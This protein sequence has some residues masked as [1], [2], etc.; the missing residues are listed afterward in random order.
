MGDRST[1]DLAWDDLWSGLTSDPWQKWICIWMCSPKSMQLYNK[2]TMN[3]SLYLENRTSESQVK[4]LVIHVER[5]VLRSACVLIG[6]QWDKWQDS[7]RR[8]SYRNRGTGLVQHVVKIAYVERT[9][10]VWVVQSFKSNAKKSTHSLYPSNRF[11]AFFLRY[12]FHNIKARRWQIV[13]DYWRQALL[14]ATSSCS[15]QPFWML[16]EIFSRKPQ[17]IQKPPYSGRTQRPVW[18]PAGNPEG[19]LGWQTCKAME[20]QMCQLR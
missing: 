7:H 4:W 15:D 13:I 16:L 8:K 18:G 17:S 10:H 6:E 3:I 2:W 14:L 19:R 1:W 9:M 20:S 11:S 12:K 5:Q